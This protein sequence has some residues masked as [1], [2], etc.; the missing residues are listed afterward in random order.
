MP[1]VRILL[2]DD[3]TLVCSAFQKLLEPQYDVVGCVG[4]GR[5]LLR[6]ATELRPDLVLLDISMPLLNGLDAGRQLK[7]QMPEVKLVY[8]TMNTAYEFAEEA[9]RFGASAYVLKNSRSSELL[10]AIDNAVRG[11]SYVSVQIRKAVERTFIRDPR[12]A[13][14]P[15]CLSRRKAEVLQ[16]F[17]E[18]WSLRDIA[19]DLQISYRTVRFHKAGIKKELGV[20]HDADLLQYAIKHGM[21]T[22]A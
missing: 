14:R 19:A 4:D 15:R 7:K 1:R 17:A 20:A 13:T 9:L 12:A 3:H 21:I 18:G 2:A 5:A 10:Q 6:A 22:A 8:L 16:M 11:R